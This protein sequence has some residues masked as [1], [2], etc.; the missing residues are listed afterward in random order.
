MIF[1][2]SDNGVN[3]QAHGKR[4]DK[5]FFSK[6]K[7]IIIDPSSGPNLRRSRSMLA[8]LNNQSSSEV[9]GINI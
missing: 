2:S 5:G 9:R 6:S 7:E 4:E 3:N 1:F 8:K